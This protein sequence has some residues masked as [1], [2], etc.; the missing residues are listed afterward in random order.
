[1]PNSIV[2]GIGH[3]C[4]GT[5]DLA[6]SHDF[7]CGILD[8]QILHKFKNESGEL[9]GY[10]LALGK[11]PF[12]ELF[13]QGEPV[14]GKDLFR[15][16]CIVVDDINNIA[17]KFQ[18]LGHTIEVRRGRSDGVLQFFVKDPDGNEIEFHQYDSKSAEIY[19]K[20]INLYK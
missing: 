6:A 9:Y 18:S 12:L 7:Y 3:I 14:N 20:L 16:I 10:I 13:N 5:N 15:H 11:G 8:A 4:L 17:T 19:H 1:M 2:R